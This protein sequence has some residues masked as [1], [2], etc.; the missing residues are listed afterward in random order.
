M[1]YS[2]EAF[3]A[4]CRAA[5]QHDPGPAG[6]DVVKQLVERATGDAQFVETNIRPDQEKERH[7]LYEDPDLKFCVLA[8]VYHDAKGSSPHDHGPS[9]AIYGQASGTTDM[10]DYRIIDKAR[11][12]QPGKAVAIRNYA[13]TPG[14]AYVYNE[15]DLHAPSRSGPTRLLRIEGINLLGVKRDKYEVVQG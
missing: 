11:D 4:D 5:L 3:V 14:T 8:H 6:R 13:L 15:G 1:S 12:G 9:W 7:L 2:L 10:T